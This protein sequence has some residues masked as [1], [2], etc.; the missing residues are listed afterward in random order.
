[1]SATHCSRSPTADFAYARWEKFQ[2][3]PPAYQKHLTQY[4]GVKAKNLNL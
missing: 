4:A 2:L 1:M 3:N